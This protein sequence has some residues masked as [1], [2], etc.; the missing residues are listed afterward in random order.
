[1]LDQRDREFAALHAQLVGMRRDRVWRF[2]S[3]IQRDFRRIFGKSGTS[4]G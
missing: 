4:S 1:M 3:M 2:A